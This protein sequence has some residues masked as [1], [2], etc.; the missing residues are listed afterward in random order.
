MLKPRLN[1]DAVTVTKEWKRLQFSAWGYTDGQVAIYF[2]GTTGRFTDIVFRLL[3]RL[4]RLM[5]YRQVVLK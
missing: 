3:L 1:F 4:L 2:I 5:S